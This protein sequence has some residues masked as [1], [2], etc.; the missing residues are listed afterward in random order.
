[1]ESSNAAIDDDLFMVDVRILVKKQTEVSRSSWIPYSRE[2]MAEF[3]IVDVF[4]IWYG[5]TVKIHQKSSI[6]G[7]ENSDV[8]Y[9]M[10]GDPWKLEEETK[11][12]SL[13][14]KVSDFVFCA[15]MT[16]LFRPKILLAWQRRI[17]CHCSSNEFSIF[18]RS[19]LKPVKHV[20]G[21]IALG[22]KNSQ[23]RRKER[24]EI[25]SFL[26]LVKEVASAVC[27]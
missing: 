22:V 17:S 9:A 11:T 16:L 21:W 15:R 20:A 14:Q 27:H 4:S 2:A 12:T 8:Y 19:Y 23:L 24:S 10:K 25:L 5:L 7:I 26:S 6:W 3:R 1:M 18:I 13:S